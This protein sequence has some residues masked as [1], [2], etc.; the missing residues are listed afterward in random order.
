MWEN[1]HKPEFE[2]EDALR[3]TE[4]RTEQCDIYRCVNPP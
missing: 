2:L 4:E 1:E 3:R